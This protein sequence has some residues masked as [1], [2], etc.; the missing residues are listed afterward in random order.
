MEKIISLLISLITTYL[1]ELLLIFIS[2]VSTAISIAVVSYFK[3]RRSHKYDDDDDV[4]ERMYRF[5]SPDDYRKWKRSK[6]G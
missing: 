2:S 4:T 5:T 1:T 6:R 3:N